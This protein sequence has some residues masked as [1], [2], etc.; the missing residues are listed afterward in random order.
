MSF[1][2]SPI[3]RNPICER[4]SAVSNPGALRS[5]LKRLADAVH[6]EEVLAAFQAGFLHVREV[7]LQ[8]V[9]DEHDGAVGAKNPMLLKLKTDGT[10]CHSENILA[11]AFVAKRSSGFANPMAVYLMEAFQQQSRFSP[12]AKTSA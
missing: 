11:K 1:F 12:D 7:H 4:F 2:L 6:N 5:L 8:G 3:N 9:I 10:L